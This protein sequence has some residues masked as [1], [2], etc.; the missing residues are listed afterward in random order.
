MIRNNEDRTGPRSTA[1]DEVPADIKQ[2]MNPM[3]FVAPTE[4]V[5][6]PS[7]GSGYPE[8][9]PLFEQNSIEIRFMTAKEEDILTSRT[10]LKEGVALDR[11]LQ[12]IIVNK[13]IKASQMLSG[14]RNAILI[15]AR[16]SAYGSWYKTEVTCPACGEKAKKA[17][18]L[19][20]PKVYHGDNWDNYEIKK[21]QKGTFIVTLPYSKLEVE[22]RLMVGEDESAI[23]KHMQKK[24]NKEEG[25]LISQMALY[26]TS[27]NGYD[28]EKTR[29]YVIQNMVAADSRYLRGAVKAFTPDLKVVDDFECR[30]CGHEEELEVPFGAD[31]F[32]PDRGV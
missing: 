6:L 26:I 31:F 32:W 3:D 13:N 8:G 10:L 1:A 21:T 9:H 29:F 20:T 24:K 25:L 23:V 2:M 27:V 28:D 11:V 17:I 15:A 7:K 18:D 19:S 4:F 16:S 14:D 12:S 5:E 22:C 30:N